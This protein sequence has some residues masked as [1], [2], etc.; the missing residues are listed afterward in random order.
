MLSSVFLSGRLGEKISPKTRYVEIDR[1]I[2]GPT[3]HFETDKF[4]VRS[5][6]ATEGPFMK[7]AVGTFV[8]LKGRLETDEDGKIVIVDELD[9]IFVMPK[10]MKK[11]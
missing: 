3:G 1:V 4:P 8:V 6:L 7:A 10:E 5:M 11:I 2:P 9:E